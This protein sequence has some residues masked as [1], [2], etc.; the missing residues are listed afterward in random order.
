M[1]LRN[2]YIGSLVIHRTLVGTPDEAKIKEELLER[3]DDGEL[4]IV[5]DDNF[6]VIKSDRTKI[7][8]AN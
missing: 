5:A 6:H 3:F 1:D 8:P 2:N 7:F 4:W